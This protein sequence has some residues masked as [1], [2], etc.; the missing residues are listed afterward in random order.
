[1]RELRIYAGRGGWFYEVRIALRVIVLG[2][3]LTRERAVLEAES[4]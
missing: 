4:V 3:Y 1:M 2:W